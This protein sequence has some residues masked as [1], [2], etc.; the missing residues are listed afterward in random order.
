MQLEKMGWKASQK[1]TLQAILLW[2]R[3]QKGSQ[4]RLKKHFLHMK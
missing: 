2:Y 1:S 4:P 3:H